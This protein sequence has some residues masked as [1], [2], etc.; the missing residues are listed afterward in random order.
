[1]LLTPESVLHEPDFGEFQKS[2]QNEALQS[3]AKKYVQIE[4]R[5]AR[6]S[7]D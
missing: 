6:L 3:A 5:R 2:A 1:M 7:D 4:K